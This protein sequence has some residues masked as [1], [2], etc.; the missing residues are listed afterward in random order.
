MIPSEAA[1]GTIIPRILAAPEREVRAA[2][3]LLTGEPGGEDRVVQVL[4][5]VHNAQRM[6]PD[7]DSP[8][9]QAAG[10]GKKE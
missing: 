3:I 9:G 8:S 1:L 7:S 6:I 10:D 4:D 5:L 2:L